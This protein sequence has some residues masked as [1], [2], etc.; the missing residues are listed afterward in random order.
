MFLF[1]R[2]Q[3]NFNLPKRMKWAAL[4]IMPKYVNFEQSTTRMKID[5]DHGKYKEIVIKFNGRNLHR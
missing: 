3:I 1:W 2:T 4:K 5:R